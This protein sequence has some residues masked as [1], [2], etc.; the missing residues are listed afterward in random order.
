MSI[1][2][3][4]F[5]RSIPRKGLVLL[6][7]VVLGLLGLMLFDRDEWRS[8]EHQEEKVA[9]AQVT[10]PVKATIEQEAKLGILREIER[11]TVDGKVTFAASVVVNGKEQESRIGVDGTFISRGEQERDRDD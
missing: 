3:I 9:L 8:E 6:A 10:A 4:N 11:T 5:L 2:R 7:F 1:P